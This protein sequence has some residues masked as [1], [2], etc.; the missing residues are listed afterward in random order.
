M[1]NNIKFFIIKFLSNEKYL[2][3]LQFMY[4]FY[5][6]GNFFF[7]LYIVKKCIGDDLII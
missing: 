7:V 6:C 5:F 2:V 3:L 1:V 4:D